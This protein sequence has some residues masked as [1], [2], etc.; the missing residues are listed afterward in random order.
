MM[1]SRGK[2][3]KFEVK[4][5]PVRICPSQIPYE[6]ARL[7]PALQDEKTATNRFVHCRSIYLVYIYAFQYFI[8]KL[9]I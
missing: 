4:P 1:I 3:K 5:A 7:N 9:N 6:I 8:L 2:L